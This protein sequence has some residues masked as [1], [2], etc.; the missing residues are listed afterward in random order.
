MRNRA[1][2]LYM[3]HALAPHL[4]QGDLD[5]ALLAD[6]PGVLQALV[7]AAKA[8]VVLDRAKYLGA[9]QAIAFGL[10]RPVVDGLRLLHFAVGPGPDLLRRS[11]SDLDCVELFFLRDL[12]KQ[13]EQRFH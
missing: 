5:A 10:E 6:Y 3:A 13:I 8:L 1:R 2:K 11:N 9:E 7:L 4:G 12:L